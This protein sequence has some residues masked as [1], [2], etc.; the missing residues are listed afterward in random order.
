MD[1][2]LIVRL[3]PYFGTPDGRGVHSSFVGLLSLPDF[4]PDVAIIVIIL[5]SLP[6]SAHTSRP[7]CF[8]SSGIIADMSHVQGLSSFPGDGSLWSAQRI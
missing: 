1:G 2:P 4:D 7:L 8:S 5:L 6:S 3:W